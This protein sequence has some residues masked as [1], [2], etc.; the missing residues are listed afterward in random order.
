MINLEY[1]VIKYEVED[2][3]VLRGFRAS[4]APPAGGEL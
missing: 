2:Q 1:A 4:D 3:P